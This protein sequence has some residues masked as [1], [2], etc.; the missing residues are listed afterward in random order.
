MHEAPAAA[1]TPGSSP[2]GESDTGE[3][4]SALHDRTLQLTSTG[5]KGFWRHHRPTFFDEFRRKK[6]LFMSTRKH[7]LRRQANLARYLYERRRVARVGYLPPL[8]GID[9]SNA[10]NL[11]CPSCSTG[12]VHAEGRKR[13]LAPESLVF[14]I[15]EQVHT[16]ALQVGFFHWGEPYLNPRCHDYVRHARKRGLWT[17]LHSNL[18][19]RNPT[20]GKAIVESGLGQ[21]VV[22]CD[23]VSQDVYEQYRVHGRVDLVFQHIREIAREKQRTGASFPFVTAKF[24]LFEHNW[25]EAIDFHRAALDAGANDVL[26]IQGFRNGIYDTGRASDELEFQLEELR[27]TDRWLDWGC[28]DLWQAM[29][30]D[31]D[32]AVF[33][34]CDGFRERDL[35]ATGEDLQHS[36][37][38]E[39]WNN[40]KYIAAREFFLRSRDLD[41]GALPS[42]CDDCGRTRR[43][44]ERAH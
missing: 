39:I 40:P 14:D 1:T 37:I 2:P 21:L 32:G 44:R 19:L 6:L 31:V 28:R 34:C 5:Y 11:R 23:G 43:H 16:T 30:F 7:S 10:C 33:P 42:P 15:I 8:I 13:G 17:V 22:S 26:F 9:P 12:V 24:I 4:G 38:R 3:V 41:P 35:F 20:L 18:S 27:Y 36:T 25:H 29:L